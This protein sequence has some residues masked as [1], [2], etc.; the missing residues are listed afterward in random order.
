MKS[1]QYFEEKKKYIHNKPVVGIDPA[2]KF[3]DCAFL[4]E[5]GISIAK[6]KR[7][8]Q[9]LDGF[10]SLLAFTKELYPNQSPIFSIECSCRLW[11]KLAAFLYERD[12]EVLIFSPLN[13]YHGRTGINLDYSH[14]DPKDA[15][16]IASGTKS[17]KFSFYKPFPVFY[18]ITRNLSIHFEK[19]SFDITRTK[20]RLRSKIEEFFPEFLQCLNLDTL[21]SIYLLERYFLPSDYLQMDIQKEAAIV[22]K[23]S[24]RNHGMSLLLK[25]RILAE[26]SIGLKISDERKEMESLIVHSLIDQLKLLLKQQDQLSK[27][28]IERHWDK[29]EFQII[30]NQ[31]FGNAVSL[32]LLKAR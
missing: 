27:E 2:K 11:I 14:S 9:S 28:M 26:Q 6:P 18:Q 25:L 8:I 13:T 1:Y 12:Y 16:I 19:V 3:I 4:N 15:T 24:N 5:N 7:F 21:T 32:T 10:N 29:R 22:S 30:H 17:G 31:L 20:N 23:L